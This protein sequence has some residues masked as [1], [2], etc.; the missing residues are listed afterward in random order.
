MLATPQNISPALALGRHP[1]EIFGI[2][3]AAWSNITAAIADSDGWPDDI[4][5]CVTSRALGGRVAAACSLLRVAAVV[6]GHGAPSAW[7]MS[8]LPRLS[9]GEADDIMYGKKEYATTR[10][11]SEAVE[12][13][14]AQAFVGSVY[15]VAASLPIGEKAVQIID[16]HLGARQA[17][18]DALYA[19]VFEALDRG[20]GA[21][22]VLFGWTGP[23]VPDTWLRRAVGNAERIFVEE[24]ASFEASLERA[25]N[26]LFAWAAHRQEI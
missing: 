13:L 24:E 10:Q 26:S 2:S 7:L 11:I 25:T 15:D 12:A 17:V 9:S 19:H 14:H 1:A 4:V 5:P 6:L 20:E 8:V 16:R 23:D 22:E 3:D 21:D 18:R